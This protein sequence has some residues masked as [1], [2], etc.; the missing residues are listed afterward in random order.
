MRSNQNYVILNSVNVAD[1]K[2]VLGVNMTAPSQFVTWECKNQNDYFYGHYFSDQLKA[3]KDL[4][5]RALNE[6]KYLEQQNKPKNKEME[7]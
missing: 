3:Q 1:A 7:R 4:C 6:V 5:V 2:F